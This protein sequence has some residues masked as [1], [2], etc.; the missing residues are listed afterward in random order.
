MNVWFPG[1][2]A[3]NAICDVLFGDVEPSGRLTTSFP[4][5]SGQCPFYYNHRN[6]CRPQNPSTWFEK[7]RSNYLD[8]PNDPVY[9][10]GY[11][12]SYTTFS[13]S[14]L[15]LSAD[16]LDADG[17]LTATVT[18]TN[19]GKREGTEVVQLYIRD[20]AG[21]ITRPVQEL[22]GFERITLKPGE[23]HEVSFTVDPEMLKFYDENLDFVA[24]PGDFELMVGPNC[25]DVARLPFRLT[26]L[27]R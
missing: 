12:L 22:K 18:V 7:Y 23:S 10:F 4:Q 16:T 27:V 20:I 11:G 3:G 5:S 19:T 21:S 1:S 25:R 24:E 14:P 2:E 9:P 8:V 15:T 26:S 13:Y 6:T 17:K